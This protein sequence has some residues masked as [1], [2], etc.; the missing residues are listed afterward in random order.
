MHITIEGNIGAGKTSLTEQLATYLSARMLLEDFSGNPF[1]PR[2]YEEPEKFAFPLEMSFMAQRYLQWKD[3]MIPDMFKEHIISDYH[4]EKSLLFSSFT[5]D[6]DVAPLFRKLATDL[7]ASL[8]IPDVL[9]Y[10][11][12]PTLRLMEN[13]RR[14]GRSFEAN[15][16]AEYL[17]TIDAA[18]NAWLKQ[19]RERA[20]I[21]VTLSR[22]YI[23][24][25]MSN[26]EVFD[27]AKQQFQKG[28]RLKLELS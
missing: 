23:T 6:D 4:F 1:L 12:V 15:I 8:S 22:G 9:I 16:E 24:D 14:R 25:Y 28:G 2:F 26:K 21:E 19:R 11:R 27:L 7:S 20:V 10:L 18:Y 17:R 13:I 3:A 5:L